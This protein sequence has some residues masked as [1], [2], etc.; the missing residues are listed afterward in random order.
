MNNL[1]P[2]YKGFIIVVKKI[3]AACMLQKLKPRKI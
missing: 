2:Q 1:K 3:C